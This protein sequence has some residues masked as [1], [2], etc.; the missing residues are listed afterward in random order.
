MISEHEKKQLAALGE[1]VAD[2]TQTE[3]GKISLQ[4]IESG[5]FNACY[6]VNGTRVPMVLRVAPSQDATLLFYE[7]NMMAQEPGLHKLV[8]EQTEIPVPE[9]LFYDDSKS[10]LDRSFMLLQR[11]PGSPLSQMPSVDYHAVLRK[12]GEYLAQLH[13]IT[14]DQFGYC[15]PHAPMKPQQ[16]WRKAFHI[17]WNRLLDDIAL[18]GLY[19]QTDVQDAR[20]LLEQHQDVFPLAL[21]GKAS[22]LHMDIWSQNILVTENSHI[23]AILDWDRAVWGDPEIEFAILDYCGISEPP[24]WE[25][26]G[27]PRDLSPEAQIRRTF[28]LLYEI[29]KYIVIRSGRHHDVPAAYRYCQQARQLMDQLRQPS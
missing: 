13:A 7:R 15:G 1:V 17:M 16:N 28:Y 3:C 2:V 12:T 20:D 4:R 23:T 6:F 26:Y 10:R 24:F 22:L 11:M 29:Q 21:P 8:H 19:H 18:T 5:K 14:T 25:G 9:I 27:K